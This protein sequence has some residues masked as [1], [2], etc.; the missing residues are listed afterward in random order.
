MAYSTPPTFSAGAALAAADLNTLG[1]DIAY[2]YGIQQGLT[3]SAAQVRRAASQ[4]IDDST[5]TAI[6]F[7]TET[8]D[9]GGWYSSG[10]D[11]VVPAG[12][13]PAGA[14]SIGI[15]LR[16]LINYASNSTG[17]RQ[18]HLQK[19]GSDV[20][21]LGVSALDGGDN[22]TLS[23]SAVTTAEAGDIFTLVA[24]QTSGGALNVAAARFT[25]LRLGVAT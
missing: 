19:N 16:G 1:T 23:M 5:E 25:V 9:V 3:F 11:V 15:D 21:A 2:L 8:L 24:K 14:T 10:T 12:A 22:T 18:I 20:D 13:I 4:N 17:K 6:S 7:D